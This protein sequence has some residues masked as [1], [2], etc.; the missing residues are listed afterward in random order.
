MKKA[1]GL[2]DVVE[3]ITKATGIKKAVKW[4]AG[5]DCGCDERKE[6]LNKVFPF[7]SIECLTEDEYNWLTKFFTEN[8]K[9]IGITTQKELLAIYNSV[10]NKKANLSGCSK[11]VASKVNDLK[12]IYDE[13][14]RE[15][16]K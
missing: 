4:I 14:N 8:R 16:S 11:C 5:D 7:K 3:K 13:Y 12:K 15:E 2:G 6:Y 10:F 9:S 1:K